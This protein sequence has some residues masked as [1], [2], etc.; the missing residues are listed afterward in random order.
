MGD[1]GQYKTRQREEVL[2]YLRS[3]AG[4][5]VTANDLCSYFKLQGRPMGTATVYRQLEQLVDEGLV[6]KY[7][8]DASGPA[9]FEF[10][11][12]ESHSEGETCFHCR[13]VKCGRLIHLHCEELAEIQEHLLAEHNFR[14]DPLRTVFYGVCEECAECI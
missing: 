3:A 4:Q 2:S 7:T 9:C 1:K 12:K 8:L 14:M 13:C 6:N 10:M 11:D 5:H